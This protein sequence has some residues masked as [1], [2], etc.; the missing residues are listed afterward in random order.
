MH[1]ATFVLSTGRC[2][3]QWLASEL[4]AAGDCA[5]VEHEPLHN[6]YA[7][8]Q[9]L[10]SGDPAALDPRRARI[11]L[12][13][14]EMIER[15]LESRDYI[16]TGH[17]CWSSIPWLLRRFAGRV[18]VVHLVR[19][20]VATAC[21][22]LSHG[23]FV[24]SLLPHLPAKEL[25][26]PSDAGV[27]FVEYRE[28]WNSLSP[29]EKSLFYWAEVNAFGLRIEQEYPAPWLRTRYEDMFDSQNDALSR[30]GRFLEFP[31]GAIERANRTTRVD[32]HHFHLA[33]WPEPERIRSHP[34]VIAVAETLG[35][36]PQ[37]FAGDQLRARFFG[38]TPT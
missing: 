28:V 12:R 2:G 6:N 23:A 21:S 30:L 13:H 9:M 16:E 8:R 27:S 10:G 26:T 3:T 18:R 7:P 37:K 4:A 5:R 36:S 14:V 17:P 31:A 15:E 19:H 35:Y 33:A 20:P 38:V 25:L 34:R 22:W 1:S 32:Q 11:V 29:I 24:P